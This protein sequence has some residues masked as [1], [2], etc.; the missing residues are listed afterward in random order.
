MAA[1]DAPLTRRQRKANEKAALSRKN[2]PVT[3]LCVAGNTSTLAQVTGIS[4][5]SP[6][7][8]RK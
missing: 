7:F 4:I 8:Q 6:E 5:G 2:L 3:T 1:Q